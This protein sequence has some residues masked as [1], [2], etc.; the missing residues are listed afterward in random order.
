METLERE[1]PEHKRNTLLFAMPN[2]SLEII[3]KKKMAFQAQIKYYA[4]ASAVGAAVPVPGLS[5][6]V[7]SALLV[8]AVTQYLLGFGLDIS[9][10]Q[11]L[12]EIT[13][14]PFQDLMAEIIS[15]L[16]AKNINKDLIMK[17][18]GQYATTL[19]LMA[20]EEGSRFIP[21]LGIPVAMGLSSMTTY[22]ILNTFLDMLAEDAQ[23]VF[24]RALGLNTSV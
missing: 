11:R 19:A 2:I 4:F 13:Q 15:P 21:I 1:L 8:D 23:R 7:D 12:A 18:L 10:L 16:A 14:V 24:K 22:S 17:L 6:A 5:A 3:N 9:S 20:A